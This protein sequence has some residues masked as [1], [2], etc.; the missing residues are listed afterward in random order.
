MFHLKKNNY[1]CAYEHNNKDF[2]FNNIAICCYLP[3]NIALC[4]VFSYSPN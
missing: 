2:D 4:S 3:C 1:I